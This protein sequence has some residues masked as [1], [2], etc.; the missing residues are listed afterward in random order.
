[1]TTILKQIALDEKSFNVTLLHKALEALGMPVAKN[2]VNKGKAGKETLKQVRTLQAQLNVPV[3]ESTLVDEATYFAIAE[4][5]SKRGLTE[6]SRSFTVTGTVRLRSG[7]IKKHQ[8]LLA[9]DLDLRGVSVFRNVKNISEI[10]K[11]GGFEFLG[12]T[13]TDTRGNYSITFYDW[14]YKRAERYKADV[15]VY[16]I[17]GKEITGLSRMVNS[18]D[19]SDKGLV[20][21]IDVIITQED[22]GIEYDVLMSKLMVFLKESKTSLGKI[23]TSSDQLVFTAGELDVDVIPG[24]HCIMEE[25]KKVR[26]SWFHSG[27]AKTALKAAGITATAVSATISLIFS[28]TL[29]LLVKVVTGIMGLLEGSVIPGAELVLDW[30][31]GRQWGMDYII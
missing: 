11:N 21:D 24:I 10:Q 26:D 6:A 1:M 31:N 12:E 23:A 15:V 16:A 28:L 25:N 29:L 7:E 8:R 20:R 4:S 22:E 3:D 5:L 14:Q 19:Y 13:V 17:E 2:E 30:K 9:F 27:E 18:E